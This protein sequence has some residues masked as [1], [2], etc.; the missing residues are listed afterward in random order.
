[1][2]IQLPLESESVR[3]TDFA[4]GIDLDPGGTALA[5]QVVIL[6]E[7][8][9]P[10]PKPVGKHDAMVALVQAAQERTG[11]FR[12]LGAVPSSDGPRRV[13][14]FRKTPGGALRSERLLCADPVGALHD[15]LDD[16]SPEFV[17]A[18]DGV[19]SLLVCT[20]GSHDVCCGTK[21]EEF[22]AW[23]ESQESLSGIEVF[24]VSHTGG[25]RF[26]PTA[27]SLP[28]GRMWAYLDAESARQ[29]LVERDDA[30]SV[31]AQCRGWWGAPTGPSQFGERAVFGELGFA[32]DQRDR[33]VDLV[34][35]DGNYDVT[36]TVGEDTYMVVVKLGREVPTIACSASGGE[37]VKPGRE[38]A[39]VSGPTKQ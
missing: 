10:W 26:S 16:E 33:F 8:D 20:Q 34:E 37:P 11:H 24:R 17:A 14:A 32:I 4:M 23:V 36:V 18:A 29:V 1:M 30:S 35:R 27:M 19:T 25:H 9:E 5:P 2:S 15:V 3:C 7:V 22:A 39:V 31:A 6:V 21:G 12:L 28:D 38:W 13:I